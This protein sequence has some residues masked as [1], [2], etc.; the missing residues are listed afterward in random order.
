MSKR[1]LKCTCGAVLVAIMLTFGTTAPARASWPGGTL[2]A[3]G[4]DGVSNTSRLVTYGLLGAVVVVLFVVAWRADR[5]RAGTRSM[6]ARINELEGERAAGRLFGAV[7]SDTLPQ[8]MMMDDREQ[9]SLEVGWR[10]TF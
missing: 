6:H 2:S 1:M 4:D 3:S 10:M 7:R 8:N 5:D 9:T